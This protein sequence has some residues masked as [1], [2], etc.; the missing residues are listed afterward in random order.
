MN[1]ADYDDDVAFL[2][3]RVREQVGPDDELEGYL[4]GQ[5]DLAVQAS[6]EETGD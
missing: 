1:Q 4:I 3:R 5:Y 6:K 2:R